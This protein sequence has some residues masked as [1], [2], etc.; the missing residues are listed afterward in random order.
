MGTEQ[1]NSSQRVGS[2]KFSS[3]GTNILCYTVPEMKRWEST[4]S[5]CGPGLLC[6]TQHT[7]FPDLCDQPSKSCW[8]IPTQREVSLSK[9][10][11]SL[12]FQDLLL[13]SLQ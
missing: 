7:Q 11:L 1:V 10:C 12:T 6:D 8:F 4:T 5:C 2:L 13:I 3:S 9:P